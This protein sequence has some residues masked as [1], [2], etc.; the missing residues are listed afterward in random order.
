MTH[1]D[2]FIQILADPRNRMILR[3]LNSVE[4]PLGVTQLADA[5]LQ[6]E[7]TLVSSPEYEEGLEQTRISLHHHRLPK[8]DDAGLVEYDPKANVISDPAPLEMSAEWQDMDTIDDLL[9]RFSSGQ[10]THEHPVGIIKGRE[11]VVEYG[12]WLFDTA[13]DEVFCIYITPDLIGEQCLT[14][15]KDACNREVDVMLG[16][17]NPEVRSLARE[18]LPDVT[19][20]EP[21]QD[22]RNDPM[23]Y[24]KVG[25][26]VLADREKITLAI[27]DE[28][29]SDGV[30]PETALIGEGETNPLVVLVR[31]LLGSRLDHLDYQTKDFRTKLPF[32]P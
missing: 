17:Q 10:R 27:L 2:R 28:P 1:E 24:P 8:L 22:W 3:H 18:W 19:V 4:G 13:I 12:R 26:L 11:R 5:L 7:N 21:Q 30:S 15:V 14:H 20:W 32:E 6:Q 9:G 16:S 25:R 23:A 31:E 29:G